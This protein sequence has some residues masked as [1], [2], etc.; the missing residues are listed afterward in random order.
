MNRKELSRVLD[1]KNRVLRLT[2]AQ[3]SLI[4]ERLLPDGYELI[5][6]KRRKYEQNKENPIL[7]V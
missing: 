1:R 5:V 7:L 3:Y 2:W 4:R 6:S